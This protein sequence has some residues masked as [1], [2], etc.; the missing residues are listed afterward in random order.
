[1]RRAILD[2]LFGPIGVF[3]RLSTITLVGY[4]DLFIFGN[5]GGFLRVV[6]LSGGFIAFHGTYPLL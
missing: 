3:T 4:G 1:M 2:Q 6:F 5:F